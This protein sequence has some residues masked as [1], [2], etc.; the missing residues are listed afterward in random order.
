MESSHLSQI[1]PTSS[2]SLKK[3]SPLKHVTPIIKKYNCQRQAKNGKSVKLKQQGKITEKVPVIYCIFPEIISKSDLLFEHH[4]YLQEHGI[5]NPKPVQDLVTGMDLLDAALR[6]AEK[7]LEKQGNPSDYSSDHGEH[8]GDDLGDAE[9][10]GITSSIVASQ[11]NAT[12]NRPVHLRN[13]NRVL[14]KRNQL[15]KDL[16][17]ALPLAASDEHLVSKEQSWG[18]AVSFYVKVKERYEKQK[19]EIFAKFTDLL[20]LKTFQITDFYHRVIALLN[21]SPDLCEEF[22]LFLLPD[23]ALLCGKFMEHLALTEM[24]SFLKKLEVYFAKQPQHM[25]KIVASWNRLAETSDLT[26]EKVR[27]T[28]LPLLKNNTLLV[29]SFLELF[30]SGR[31]PESKMT[32]FA[33]L[34]CDDVDSE[35]SGEEDLYESIEIPE[36]ND[37]PYGGENCQCC[38]HNSTDASY[39]NR[40]KHCDPCGMKFISGKVFKQTE[41]GLRPVKIEFRNGSTASNIK[42]LNVDHQKLSRPRSRRGRLNIAQNSTKQEE[43]KQNVETDDEF[44][45]KVKSPRQRSKISKSTCEKSSSTLPLSLDRKLPVGKLSPSS[46]PLTHDQD[47]LATLCENSYQPKLDES[48]S[49]QSDLTISK[50]DFELG[51]S[52]CEG[53]IEVQHDDNMLSDKEYDDEELEEESL[54]DNSF[55]DIQNAENVAF[56]TDAKEDEVG[57]QD[58]TKSVEDISMDDKD[59]NCEEEEEGSVDI[60][61]A[62]SDCDMEDSSE[63]NEGASWT[64]EED[65]IILCTFKSEPDKE[66]TLSKINAQLPHRTLEEISRRFQLLISLI[67]RM[68]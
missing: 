65:R 57:V 56:D 32:D 15:Q 49:L 51:S 66:K 25:K 5:Q 31:P 9:E 3:S 18:L 37:D 2:S 62:S 28:M 42:R 17:H 23:Q 55:Q 20:H 13:R 21:D 39:S 68:G 60:S 36:E 16:E 41:H 50:G 63:D 45:S 22:L 10:E 53:I 1:T 12:I 19:P 48:K 24:T 47:G 64:R 40:S 59:E 29:D 58:D 7:Y 27:N 38:C 46:I 11:Q 61:G 44:P 35:H 6:R 43:C 8:N 67:Q 52:E 4:L 14:K 33:Q 26:L 30:P 54:Q 34:N